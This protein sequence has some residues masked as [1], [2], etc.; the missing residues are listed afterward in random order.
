[1][2]FAMSVIEVSAFGAVLQEV[3]YLLVIEHCDFARIRSPVC[4]RNWRC[5]EISGPFDI[6]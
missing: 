3:P 1:M 5:R 6:Q 4:E 2:S